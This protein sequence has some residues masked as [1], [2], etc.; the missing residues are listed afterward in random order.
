M[1]IM[2]MMMIMKVT[3]EDFKS[4]VLLLFIPGLI[5]GLRNCKRTLNIALLDPGL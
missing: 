3:N 1:M 5:F 2:M 4:T